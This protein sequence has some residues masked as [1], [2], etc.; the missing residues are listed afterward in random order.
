MSRNHHASVVVVGDRGVLIAGDSGLGKSSLAVSLI[1]HYRASGKFARLVADD[2][3]FLTACAGRAVAT[4]PAPIAGLIE[5]FGTGPAGMAFE[6]QAVI[7]LVV[8]LVPGA[9]P[10]LF[11]ETLEL[12]PGIFVPVIR[13]GGRN[14]SGALDAVAA[15]LSG[16]PFH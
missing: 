7:D 6:R 12:L 16:P 14:T 15:C 10:R 9:A 11:E 1:A 2:Q 8:E 3:V 5:V 13:L 4:T